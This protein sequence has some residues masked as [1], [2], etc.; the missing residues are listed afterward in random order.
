MNDI[1]LSDLKIICKI[2]GIKNYSRE[3]K[4]TI[5]NL[6]SEKINC[7]KIQ[8]W[9]RSLKRCPIS[10]D[11][12]SHPCF[13]FKPNNSSLIHY[14]LYAL[15][16]Y[17]IDSGDFRDPASRIEYTDNNLQEMDRIDKEYRSV[18]KIET[19]YRSVVKYSKDKKYYRKKEEMKNEVI[20]IER[21]LDYCIIDI[22]N[23]LIGNYDPDNDMYSTSNTL[24]VLHH[25]YLVN[26][27]NHFR[28]LMIK[29]RD[30]ASYVIGKNIKNFLMIISSVEEKNMYYYEFSIDYLEKLKEELR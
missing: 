6:I 1:L 9:Y 8:R 12:I 3:K 30:H 17:L 7:L 25:V 28:R 14:N 11:V 23:Y 5:V 21:I 4:Q 26:Y 2:V 16:D 15:K 29:D 18:K 10:L 19:P 22:I 24:F 27:K 20:I 13:V